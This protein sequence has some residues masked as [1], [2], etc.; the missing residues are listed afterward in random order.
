MVLKA[1]IGAYGTVFLTS[2]AVL[3]VGAFTALHIRVV[4]ENKDVE[5]FVE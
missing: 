1:Q 2:A 4:K 5:V 3:L